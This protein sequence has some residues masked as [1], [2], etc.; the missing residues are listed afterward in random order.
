MIKMACMFTVLGF[1]SAPA[2]AGLML[3]YNFQTGLNDGLASMSFTEGGISL[4]VTAQTSI[5]S[6]ALVTQNMSGGLGVCTE[7]IEDCTDSG[8]KHLD[9]TGAMETL[10]F[11]IAGGGGL[12]LESFSFNAYT[13][14]SANLYKDSFQFFVDGMEVTTGAFKP[15]VADISTGDPNVWSVGGSFGQIVAYESFALKAINTNGKKSSF[16]VGAL[17]ATIVPIPSTLALLGLGVMGLMAKRRIKTRSATS[18][19]R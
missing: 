13:G 19:C 3:T 11:T 17:S 6:A 7:T 1:V 10:V 8:E 18:E 2:A 14:T 9:G 4:N 5:P 12:L 16:R 15:A